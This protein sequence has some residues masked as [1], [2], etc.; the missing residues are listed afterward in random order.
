[1]YV[2][3]SLLLALPPLS[4]CS[5][6]CQTPP[7]PASYIPNITDCHQLIEDIFAIS[8][9]QHD[10]PILWS[11]SPSAFVRNRRLP[12]SFTDPLATS[13][14][15]FIVDALREGSEDTFPTNLVAEQAEKIVRKCM[16]RGVD[17]A[18]TVGAA[19]VGPKRVIVVVLMKKGWMRGMAG[20]GVIE[21]NVTN[22]T[23]LGLGNYWGLGPSLIGEGQFR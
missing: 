23:L 14:C 8:T 10:E 17:R 7:P 19:A 16:E 5:P 13:D 18:E 6:I 11:R 1:M 21:L 22:V 15:E 20:G 3:L 4:L 9:M 12:Y 2:L